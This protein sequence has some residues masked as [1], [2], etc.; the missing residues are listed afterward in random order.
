MGQVGSFEKLTAGGMTFLD[1][2]VVTILEEV[3][4]ERFGG[5]ATDYQLIEDEDAGGRTEVRL[6]IHPR[7]GPVD[8]ATVVDVFLAALGE[9]VGPERVMGYLWR[10]AQVV[11]VERRPPYTTPS[12]KILHLHHARPD[13]PR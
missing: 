6:V 2:D 11:R 3:L 4:P 1:A 10:D 13:Q 5:I 12:G 8:P 7:I 9:G